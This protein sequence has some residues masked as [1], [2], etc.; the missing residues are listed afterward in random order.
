M[1]AAAARSRIEDRFIAADAGRAPF[2]PGAFDV[3]VSA[4]VLEYVTDA[5]A[6][7]RGVH[8]LLRPGG[9]LIVSMP[10]RASLFRMLSRMEEACERPLSRLWRRIRG[11]PPAE[12]HHP[13]GYKHSLWTP[14]AG[15]RLLLA[16]GFVVQH[17]LYNTYG[18]RGWLGNLAPS[19]RL[20]AWMTR[21]L[22]EKEALSAWLAHTVVFQTLRLD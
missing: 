3:V 11:L 15:R 22:A 10:N 4:G 9:T 8:G 5:A 19:L 6:V 18:M 1:L 13:A 12:R 16:C 7:L 21:R 20:A 17:T 14:W 2:R